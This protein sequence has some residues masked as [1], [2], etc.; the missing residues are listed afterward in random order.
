MI[1]ESFPI[2]SVTGDGS[3]WLIAAADSILGDWNG[4]QERE[5]LKSSTNSTKHKVKWYRSSAK[6]GEL[7]VSLTD[8]HDAIDEGDVLYAENNAHTATS[9]PRKGAN[10]YIRFKESD[11]LGKIFLIELI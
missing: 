3:K 9:S 10:V 8:Y 6:L 2:I 11:T 4:Y 5:V 7:N 1:Y